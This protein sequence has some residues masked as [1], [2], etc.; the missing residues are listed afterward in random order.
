MPRSPNSDSDALGTPSRRAALRLLDAVL[1]RGEPL[2]QALVAATRHVYGPDRGL[3]HAI[4][5]E[6]LRRLPDLDALIDSVTERPLPDDAKAR[7]ALRIALVQALVLGTPHHAAI[8]TVLPLVDGGPRKL[9]HGVFGAIVRSGVLLPELPALPPLVEA[10][11][12]AA[13]GPAMTDGAAQAI[14]APPPLDITLADPAETE[15]WRVALGGTSLLPGHV[16]VADA[17]SVTELPGFAEGRWWVQ[18]IAASLPARL[19]ADAVR[20]QGEAPARAIDLC[21]APGG[22]T[23][24]LAAAGFTVAAVDVSNARIKRLRENL[25]RTRLKAEV[26]AGD[27]LRWQPEAPADALLIDAPCSATGIFRRHPDVLHR[28][29]PPIIEEMAALQ[30][31]LWARA[32]DW[33]RPGGSLVFA[34]C[35]LEPAE[36]EAQLARFLADRPD[37]AIDAPAAA[38][39]PEG[40]PVHAEGY[41]RT[42]P[43]MLAAAGGCDGFFMV[44]L[45]R[46]G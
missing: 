23:L 22:K 43:G 44:R 36:G 24:Q 46:Q 12:E 4:A 29:H 21:A 33:V 25:F 14:A 45:R 34:T 10:R 26:I 41:V 32:A 6:V 31:R 3:A 16:R 15:Q 27:V 42:L 8:A 11:W 35:S 20:Q 17:G 37:Y 40:I 2:E 38:L 13:W 30:A 19:L 18:D 7:M 9:V 39:L 5:A 28:V 1:R